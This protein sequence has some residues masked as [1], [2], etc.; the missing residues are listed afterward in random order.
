MSKKQIDTPYF[1]CDVRHTGRPKIAEFLF[2]RSWF[3]FICFQ[4]R[5]AIPIVR[6][7]IL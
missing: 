3:L 4:F 5:L 1:E 2:L 6:A 7:L